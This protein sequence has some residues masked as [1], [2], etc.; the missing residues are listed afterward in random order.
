M[1]RRAKDLWSR[2]EAFGDAHGGEN[3]L[4]G[5]TPVMAVAAVLCLILQEWTLA[6][7]AGVTTLVG[8]LFL[9]R[10]RRREQAGGS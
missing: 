6:A 10:A 9:R 1:L 7:I 2:W 8:A 3:Y 5:M 4:R